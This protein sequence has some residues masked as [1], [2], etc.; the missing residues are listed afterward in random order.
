MNK[1]MDVPPARIPNE[2][3]L[4]LIADPTESIGPRGVDMG[5]RLPGGF[6]GSPWVSKL[7]RYG[8]GLSDI[9][10]I[11]GIAAGGS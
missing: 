9:F 11:I 8:N 10:I 3:S 4:A 5:A 2:L 1:T 7:F 6:G